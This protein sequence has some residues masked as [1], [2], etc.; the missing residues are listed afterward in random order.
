MKIPIL[1]Y[2]SIGYTPLSVK[3]DVFMSQMK[4]LE[5]QNIGVVSPHNLLKKN[6]DKSKRIVVITFDDCFLDVYENAVP[7]LCDL[8]IKATFF[9]V[10]GYDALIRWG[11]PKEKRWSDFKKNTFAIPFRYMGKE[12]RKELIK[13]GMEIGA[14]TLT[15]RNLTEL[16]DKEIKA[17]IV[18]SKKILEDELEIEI[19]TFCYP[20]G[21]YNKKIIEEVKQAGFKMACTTTQG[22]F[23]I[24]DNIYEIKRFGIG[25]DMEGFKAIVEGRWDSYW[26][27]IKRIFRK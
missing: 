6:I 17:E 3:V 16:S 27:K 1:Y 23:S 21:K 19:K 15:H 8:G 20:R 4:Y 9:A 7:I 12:Q 14:H 10:P 24:N 11:S 25:E 5:K 18:K 13:L 2:H 22:Y 26:Y